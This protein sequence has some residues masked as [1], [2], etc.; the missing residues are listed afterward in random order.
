MDTKRINTIRRIN[1]L[2]KM[3][4][5]W[6][7]NGI[8]MEW[9]RLTRWQDRDQVRPGISEIRSTKHSAVALGNDG[10][11]TYALMPNGQTVQLIPGP[12]CNDFLN[13]R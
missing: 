6:R 13:G 1:F 5:E 2:K 8:S 10:M 11:Y 9:V 3:R 4:T 12:E 7:D